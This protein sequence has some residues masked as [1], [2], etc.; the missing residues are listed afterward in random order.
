MQKA[1]IAL[2]ALTL[3]VATAAAGGVAFGPRV[4]YTSSG[5]LDQVHLGGH[6]EVGRLGTNLLIVPSLEV[7]SGDGTLIAVNGDVVYDFTELAVGPWGLY[8]GGGPVL[9]R[10]DGDGA[11]STDFALS[12]VVGGTYDIRSDRHLFGEIRLGI[13]DAPDL[14]L[15]LG[16]TF[17]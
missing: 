15:T 1:I 4:G 11:D 5:S 13:E 14:K 3:A 17:R 16:L 10:Y 12:V 7:G 8:A 2:A 6:A 9:T